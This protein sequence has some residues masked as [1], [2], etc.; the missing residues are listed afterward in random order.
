MFLKE[1][2]NVLHER[3]PRVTFIFQ[4]LIF[5]IFALFRR[6]DKRACEYFLFSLMIYDSF[7]FDLIFD[8]IIGL[9]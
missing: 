1:L 8:K 6:F 4:I 9:H 2:V 5:G 7:I 3:F